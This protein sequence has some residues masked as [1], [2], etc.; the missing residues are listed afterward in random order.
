VDR[1]PDSFVFV[2]TDRATLVGVAAVRRN[3]LITL[4]YVSPDVRFKG[5]SKAL[6]QRLEEQAVACGNTTCR[7]ASTQTARRCYQSAGFRDAPT[8]PGSNVSAEMVKTLTA[9]GSRAPV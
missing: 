5:V 2:A 7:L 6:L 3:G 9:H 4:N 1:A 8:A